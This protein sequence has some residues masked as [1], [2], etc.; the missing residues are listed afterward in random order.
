MIAACSKKSAPFQ[1]RNVL[2][3]PITI[4]VTL[5]PSSILENSLELRML[6]S[7]GLADARI[8]NLSPGETADVAILYAY[9]S[10]YLQMSGLE[11]LQPPRHS[12]PVAS[13]A[14]V[15]LPPSASSASSTAVRTGNGINSDSEDSDSD[16]D[17]SSADE[18]SD[19]EDDWTGSDVDEGDNADDDLDRANVENEMVVR[20]LD[21]TGCERPVLHFGCRQVGLL[22]LSPRSSRG[23]GAEP[24]G[25]E[26]CDLGDRFDDVVIALGTEFSCPIVN[27]G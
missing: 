15:L 24:G 20:L 17:S 16:V 9:D 22:R 8:I 14:S 12:P 6:F 23:S 3:I 5:T 10:S 27:I 11:V 25:P 21:A 4:Y 1:I 13:T 18:S 2:S 7:G 19:G 26:D